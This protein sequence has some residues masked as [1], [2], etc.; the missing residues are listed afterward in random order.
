MHTGHSRLAIG[1]ALLGLCGA[2]AWGTG[3]GPGGLPPPADLDTT[4][5]Q[6]EKLKSGDLDKMLNQRLDQ[7]MRKPAAR[8]SDHADSDAIDK[9]LDKAAADAAKSADTPGA[10]ATG[11]AL[12]KALGDPLKNADKGPAAVGKALQ[13]LKPGRPNVPML[14]IAI[15]G[16]AVVLTLLSVAVVRNFAGRLN[17]VLNADDRPAAAPTDGVHYSWYYRDAATRTLPPS[18]RR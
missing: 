13:L 1:L 18:K 14:I 15:I 12:P 2:L 4:L 16:T 5:R 7:E 11:K 10:P 3:E 6:A 17:R 9:A 8:S